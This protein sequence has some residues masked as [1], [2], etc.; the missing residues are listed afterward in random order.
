MAPD[1]PNIPTDPNVIDINL[2]LLGATSADALQALVTQLGQVNAHLEQL[3]QATYEGQVQAARGRTGRSGVQ[4]DGQLGTSASVSGEQHRGHQVGHEGVSPGAR[5]DVWEG[6]GTVRSGGSQG[7]TEDPLESARAARD[8]AA[9]QAERAAQGQRDNWRI[10]G[11]GVGVGY[12]AGDQSTRERLTS[13]W[14]ATKGIPWRSGDGSVTP[15]GYG[16]AGVILDALN[17]QSATGT[18]TSGQVSPGASVGSAPSVGGLGGGPGTGP[19]PTRNRDPNDPL[20]NVNPG[21]LNEPML[22]PQHYGGQWTGQDYLSFASKGFARSYLRGVDQ[23]AGE[24]DSPN[25]DVSQVWKARAANTLANASQSYGMFHAATSGV[26]RIFNHLTGP[27]GPLGYSIRSSDVEATGTALGYGKGET[28]IG[29]PGFGARIPFSGYT[30]E[31]G[32]EGLRSRRLRTS[33]AM[34]PDINK[35]QAGRIVDAIEAHGWSGNERDTIAYTSMRGLTSEGQNPETL[36]PLLDRSLRYGTGSLQQFN[37]AMQDVGHGARAARM[38]LDEFHT[39]MGTYAET[40]QSHGQTFGQGL[41]DARGFTA[42]TGMSPT[43]GAGLM[44]NPLVQSMAMTR[45]GLLPA[46]TGLL[47][48]AQQGQLSLQATDMAMQLTQ[49]FHRATRVPVDPN[50]PDGPKMTID[51]L[52][53]QYAQAASLLGIPLD[54]FRQL[55]RNRRQVASAGAAENALRQFGRDVSSTRAHHGS[56][57]ALETHGLHG[58]PSWAYIQQQLHAAG[59]GDKTIHDIHGMPIEKR[60]ARAQTVLE[61]ATKRRTG[62]GIDSKS[63]HVTVKFTGM[64]ERMLTTAFDPLHVVRNSANAGKSFL[65][66]LFGDAP[67]GGIDMLKN[68]IP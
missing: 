1:S 18:P 10:Q 46:Q 27:S 63:Q 45:Y 67:G 37:Q 65:P 2:S 24:A 64:A 61:D 6:F 38:G 30:S 3:G 57:S 21:S 66:A 55:R 5:D 16:R 28:N 8:Q 25:A 20:Y 52:D 51:P 39:S 22:M 29:V 33:L 50:H 4:D 44:N 9:A 53:A 7:Q 14:Q 34:E 58:G 11:G 17:R 12:D 35:E 23:G 42:T 56:L 60:A 32:Q 62:R 54:E 13:A 49:G 41:I 36:M 68:L 59:V 26:R 43:V 48:G 15:P 47:G 31:A 19:N 40:A